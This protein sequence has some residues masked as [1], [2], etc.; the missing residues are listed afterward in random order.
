MIRDD[1]DFRAHVDYVHYNPVKHGL[2][3]AP[4]EWPYSSYHRAVARGE[5]P[6]G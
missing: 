5:V 4:A 3:A 1:H 2:A 6:G